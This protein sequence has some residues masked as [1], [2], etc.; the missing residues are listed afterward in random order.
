MGKLVTSSLENHMQE[1]MEN[2]TEAWFGVQAFR[3]LEVQECLDI[4]FWALRV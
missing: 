4:K 1:K 3:G 2:I